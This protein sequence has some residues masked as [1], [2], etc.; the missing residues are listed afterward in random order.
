MTSNAIVA[1]QRHGEETREQQNRTNECPW[2]HANLL[3]Y[4]SMDV[5]LQR[6]LHVVKHKTH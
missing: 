3:M 5:I 6:R 1:Q 2:C 4:I